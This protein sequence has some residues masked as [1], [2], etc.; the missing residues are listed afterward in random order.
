VAPVLIILTEKKPLACRFAAPN[1][2]YALV[3][4][5]PVVLLPSQ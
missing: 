3:V 4:L 2:E 5:V 1:C